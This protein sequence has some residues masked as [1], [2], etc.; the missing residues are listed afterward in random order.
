MIKRTLLYV[1]LLCSLGF[2]ACKKE[3]VV[4]DKDYKT[5]GTG[6]NDFLSSSAYSSLLLEIDYMPGY[7]PDATS[8]T[9]LV[10]FLNTF[11]VQEFA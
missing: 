7:A 10:T 2:T 11:S 6:A 3:D 4:D 8:V 5:L 1:L 9:N